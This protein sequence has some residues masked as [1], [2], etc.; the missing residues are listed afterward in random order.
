MG[1]V[2]AEQNKPL[3]NVSSLRGTGH[4]CKSQVRWTAH[5]DT[6]E[7]VW[8][9]MKNILE[10]GQ[11]G[12]GFVDYWNFFLYNFFWW[13]FHCRKQKILFKD[14]PMRICLQAGRA[15]HS[16]IYL[17][18]NIK[19]HCFWPWWFQAWFRDKSIPNYLQITFSRDL[20]LLSLLNTWA[21]YCFVLKCELGWISCLISVSRAYFSNEMFSFH[22]ALSAKISG[23]Y[24]HM[25]LNKSG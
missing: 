7:N 8:A 22:Y 24:S 18:A 19:Y 14:N 10:W 3:L 1:Q 25:F 16:M 20:S 2:P 6:S 5:L 11:D 17:S 9:G 4:K 21:F 23:K 12:M 13:G 15:K